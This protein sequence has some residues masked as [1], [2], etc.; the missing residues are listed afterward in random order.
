MP[1]ARP[2]TLATVGEDALVRLFGG[3]PRRM[4]SGT[5]LLGPG[6]DAAAVRPRR[7]ANLLLTTD[8]LAEGVHFRRSWA[9]PADLG[10][11]LAAVNASDIAAM[12]GKPLW[13]LL[14]VA[15]PPDSDLTFAT[16]VARGLRAAARRFGFV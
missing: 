10:W 5:V 2:Q 8:L 13:A 14:S 11:K 1:R 3:N 15:L 6:D 16:G 9:T 4:S 7:G 12:G